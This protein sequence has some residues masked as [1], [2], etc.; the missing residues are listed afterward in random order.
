[1]CKFW[2][3]FTVSSSQVGRRR[4]SDETGK[5]VAS[6]PTVGVLPTEA[7][8]VEK[9]V[10]SGVMSSVGANVTTSGVTGAGVWGIGVTGA[11]VWGIGVT[12]AGVTGIGVT[13][14]GVRGIGVTG[15]GVSGTGAGVIAASIGAGVVVT[16]GFAV[17]T[18]TT[19]VGMQLMVGALLALPV[20]TLSVS[21]D[22]GSALP[23]FPPVDLPDFPPV[24]PLFAPAVKASHKDSTGAHSFD[25]VTQ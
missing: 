1:V 5:L 3:G 19:S 12:G 7:P 4:G 18:S 24:L 6:V 15:A 14:A 21:T 9:G 16:V 25:R 22:T 20:P 17:I 13:G 8:S 11:G 2:R 23:D 10:G